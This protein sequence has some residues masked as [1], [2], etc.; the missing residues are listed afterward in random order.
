[1]AAILDNYRPRLAAIPALA[2]FCE[3]AEELL[4]ADEPERLWSVEPF[5]RDLVAS[6]VVEAFL[7]R[8]LNA[9]ASNHFYFLPGASD[10]HAPLAESSAY[11]LLIRWLAPESVVSVP[12]STLT[13]HLLLAAWGSSV[14]VERFALEPPFRIDVF[15]RSRR[16]VP[17]GTTELE[18]GTVAR[19]RSPAETFR[20]RLQRPSVLIQLQS[21]PTVPLRWVFH[22]ET[23]EPVR[24]AAVSLSSSRL[25]FTCHTLAALGSPTSIPALTTLTAHP[26]HYVRWAA[27][28]SICSISQSDGI[29]C[30]RRALD[31]DH[32]HVRNAARKTLAQVGSDAANEREA[33]PWH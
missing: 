30:L 18:P 12:V 2:T 20:L 1:M 6:D 23:L 31:D 7:L 14:D 19:F 25:Q 4:R 9:I 3:R 26:E 8:E 27:I 11:S 29:E 17:L 5:F 24:A 32:P 13:E 21:R 15:D 16:L 33:Q 22:P 28:Q 10:F